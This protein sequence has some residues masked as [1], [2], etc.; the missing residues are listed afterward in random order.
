MEGLEFDQEL[1]SPERHEFT[2]FKNSMQ[3]ALYNQFR[4]GVY[5]L[6][7]FLRHPNPSLSDAHGT[8]TLLPQS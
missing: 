1:V 4:S 5:I 2:F 8:Q 7:K 6:Q 3:T